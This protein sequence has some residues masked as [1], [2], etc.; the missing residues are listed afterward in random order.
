LKTATFIFTLGYNLR[1]NQV[2]NFPPEWV[3]VFAGIHKYKDPKLLFDELEYICIENI[4]FLRKNK[5]KKY[6]YKYSYNPTQK[7]KKKIFKTKHDKRNN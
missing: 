1:R 4:S 5:I 3:A 7:T 2:V 6:W